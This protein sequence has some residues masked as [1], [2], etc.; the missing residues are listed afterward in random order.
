[1]FFEGNRF[2]VT[3]GTIDFLNPAAI[4]PFFDIEAETRVHVPSVDETYRITLAING[5]VGGHMSVSANS[6]PPLAPA[7]IVELLFGQ[8]TDLTDPELRA[9]R[10]RDVSQTEEQLL[11]AGLLRVLA[12]PL[13]APITHAVEQTLNINTIQLSPSIGTANDPLAPTARLIIG[14]R[15]SDRAY[16]TFSRALGTTQREQIIVLEYDQ[17]DRLG[18]ILTQTGDRTFSIDFRVRRSFR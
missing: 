3:H 10:Q 6:D 13:A 5:S 8:T 12:A 14:Q 9:L 7:D 17:S 16:L 11:R 18:W 1:M 4:E 15:L 2:L